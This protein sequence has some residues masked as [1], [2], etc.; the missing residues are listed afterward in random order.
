M[1]YTERKELI[2]LDDTH[3]TWDVRDMTERNRL[4]RIRRHVSALCG[5]CRVGELFGTKPSQKFSA[6]ADKIA[7]STHLNAI[8]AALRLPNR[9][10]P[11]I[12]CVFKKSASY[13]ID[14]PGAGRSKSE[15]KNNNTYSSST[16]AETCRFACW[17]RSNNSLRAKRRR[18]SALTPSA[19]AR[20]RLYVRG[21]GALWNWARLRTACVRGA[22]DVHE[23]LSRSDRGERSRTRN[24]IARN[25]LRGESWDC[26]FN[27]FC[28]GSVWI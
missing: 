14:P 1:I 6:M 17:A 21:W 15:K 23:R 26:Y 5:T 11:P 10:L 13:G 28:W 9:I 7:E 25:K 24:G 4:A 20:V 8:T 2:A 22:P 12:E 16:R 3:K 18:S 27:F 19:H